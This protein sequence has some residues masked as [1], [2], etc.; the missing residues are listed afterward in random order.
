[1]DKKE[2]EKILFELTE[3]EKYYKN[4]PGSYSN[5]YDSAPCKQINGQEIMVLEPVFKP[6]QSI[7]LRKDSR[8]GFIPFS[9]YTCINIQY[10]YSG[11]ATYWINGKEIVLNQGDICIFDRNVIRSKMRSG[12]D[13][14]MIQ[15]YMKNDYFKNA[16]QTV[17]DRN[18]LAQFVAETITECNNHENYIIFRTNHNKK[19]ADLF[20]QLL[21]AYFEDKKYRDIIIQNYFSIIFIE[22]LNLYQKTSNEN[23]IQFS[24]KGYSLAFDL[25]N[26]IAQNFKDCSLAKLSNHFGYH[27][28]YICHILKKHLNKTFKE[29]QVEHRMERAKRYLINSN[30][31]ISEIAPRVGYSNLN[32]FY[33]KFYSHYQMTPKQFKQQNT[34]K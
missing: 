2:L 3:K 30:I 18:I 11:S 34:N 29:L 25:Q 7:M 19:I 6:N 21:I 28:K 4:N 16:V 17:N 9:I 1:M 23:V 10:I 8:Y 27:E 26:Y 33:S 24:D 15:I 22:L 20:D 31:P 32:Q 14:I 13:D 5:R 12:Y